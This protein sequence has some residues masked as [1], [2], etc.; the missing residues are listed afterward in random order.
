MPIRRTTL[1]ATS[2]AAAL[3]VVVLGRYGSTAGVTW[4]AVAVTTA[5]GL[6]VGALYAMS[7]SGLV[8]VYA[9]T[10]IFN[11]A[12]GAIGVFAAFLFWELHENRGWPTIVAMVIVVGVVAPSIG[13][14]LDIVLMRRLRSA[15]LVVQLMV[16]VG[17]MVFILVLVGQI[18]SAEKARRIE[19]FFGSA[20]G[21]SIGPVNILWH[22]LLVIGVALLIAVLLR[23]LLFQTRLGVAMRAV[24]DNRD[25]AALTGAAPNAVSSFA[26]ALGSGLAALAGILIAPEV[27]L[28]PSSL[29][30]VIF[31]A[32]AA[33]A[34]GR[35]RSLPLTVAGALL[36]GLLQ[37]H[38]RLWITDAS[39]D[40][41]FYDRAIAPIVLFVAVLAV[42]QSRLEVGR[43]ATNLRPRERTTAPWEGLIGAV[44]IVV[45]MVALSGGW[46]DLGVW[47]PGPWD[48]I[49]LNNGIAAF[50]LALIGISLVPLTG[51][52][53][54]VNFAPLAFAGF[55]AWIFLRLS[56]GDGN[57]LW[58]PLVGLLCMPLGALV[59]LPAA[60]L[61][62]LYLALASMAFAQLMALLFFTHDSILPDAVTG[63]QFGDLHIAGWRFDSR[64]ELLLLLATVFAITTLSLVAL[65][66]SRYGR[67]WIALNDSAAASATLGVNVVATKVTAYAFSSAI[68]GMAGVFWATGK[69]TIDSTRDFDLL[70]GFEIVLLMAA[71]GVSI[72]AAAMFLSFRFIF[73]A[74]ADRL[75]AAGGVGAIVW[76]LDKLAIFG[77]GMLAIG[78]VVN[79]RGAVFEMGR[80]FAPLLPWRADA[81]AEQAAERAK[82]AEVEVG[83][84]GLAT[85]F[86]EEAVHQ[87]DQ[88]LGI[89]DLA[90][91]SSPRHG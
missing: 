73:V 43:L 67:R 68:A 38:A 3:V 29:N 13:I 12:Q 90:P 44:G 50:S 37:V 18:W 32:L 17:L 42:P 33:A 91:V 88:H 62:G 20:N 14:V 78:M 64:R 8:V 36:I 23:I 58:L 10:G 75:D 80:G 5:T 2:V 79:Q 46:L 41:Q 47:D 69:G 30:D 77:P 89:A 24:V 35:L 55:G 7:A 57:L 9:T 87:L 27:Q 71:A 52:A 84:Y 34:V 45:A 26:W 51:W 11:F 85:P 31:V 48:Q 82:S 59:A 54:Q 74:L 76:I 16:T 70:V 56:D 65:R 19:H 63:T 22:R 66:R 83:D 49:G 6:A 21:F 28:D 15:P 72:P 61:R 25:L 81:R 1:L 53:G 86:T 39:A 60:R 4:E 40:F